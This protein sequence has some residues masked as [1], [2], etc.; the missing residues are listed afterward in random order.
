MSN[1][2]TLGI[3]SRVKHPQFGNGVVIQAYADS[4]EITFMDYGT[5]TILKSFHGLEILDFVSG[6]MDLLSFAK[7]ERIITKIIRN[8]SD[9][10]EVV[11]MGSKWN[12]GLMILQP[13]DR[14]LKPKE[15]PVETFFHKIVMVRDRLRVMEQRINGSDLSD[16]EKVNLQQ[17]ITK[18]Y[19]SLTTFN[20]LFADK[21]DYFTG[22]QK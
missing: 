1:E 17:Y 16:E 7:V 4:Y 3:G 6:E 21:D 13:G 8:F 2:L 9:I 19:G 10:Q 12:G 18:I 11:P 5:K 22:E 14:S 15:V 20:V